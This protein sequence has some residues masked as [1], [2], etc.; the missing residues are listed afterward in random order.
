MNREGAN[1]LAWP[2]FV[3]VPKSPPWG[4]A[5]DCARLPAVETN[6]ED[7]GPLVLANAVDRSKEK[8]REGTSQADGLSKARPVLWDLGWEE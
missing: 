2:S 7:T 4:R 8:Q 6:P 3:Y 5:E 1:R